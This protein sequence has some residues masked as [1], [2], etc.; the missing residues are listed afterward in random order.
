MLGFGVF[1]LSK[2]LPQYEAVLL[3]VAIVLL[4]T[5]MV[6]HALER[7]RGVERYWRLLSQARGLSLVPESEVRTA[8]TAPL[9]GTHAQ[10][11]EDVRVEA[12]LGGE[13]GPHRFILVRGETLYGGKKGSWIAFVARR[14]E[15]RLPQMEI[16]REGEF[17]RLG[18]AVL[19]MEDLDFPE[20]PV[21][22]KAYVVKGRPPLVVS[23]IL[24]G[25]VRTRI[26][27]LGEV[28]VK[29]AD[30]A[31]A[32]VRRGPLRDEEVEP[33]LDRALAVV[34]ALAS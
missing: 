9:K 29:G 30:D 6:R 3:P 32:I 31:L 7:Q 15:W 4:A 12:A 14:S 26:R 23:R 17:H 16:T 20:D 1:L 19:G 18:Q 24:D 27:L 2:A 13:L 34:R 33:F 22:S 5:G 21:F 28:Q 11:S 8:L 10:L 25:E